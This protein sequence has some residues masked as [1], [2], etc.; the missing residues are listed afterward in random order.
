MSSGAVDATVEWGR[1]RVGGLSTR[2]RHLLAG[3]LL[4][5]ALWEVAGR[6]GGV[7]LAPLSSVLVALV[8][9][10][11]SGRILDPLATTLGRLVVGYALAVGIG[12][13]VGAAMG[14]SA[15][16][17][18]LLDSYVTVLFVTS[19][20]SMLPLLIIFAGTGLGF[21]V[22]VVLLFAVFHVVLI[23][24]SGVADVD[25]DLVD[26]GRVFGARGHRLYRHVLLPAALPAVGA[27]LRV[28][29][30]R[31]IKGVVVAELWIYSGIGN[32]LHGYQ[33]YSQVDYAL[34]VV[35]TLMLLAVASVRS[36]R[37]LEGRYAPWAVREG[38]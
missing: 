23:V 10:Y 15:T 13:P 35:L 8:D 12:V 27:A 30:D 26:T 9:L 1:D 7:T 4:I 38:A 36:L 34:A 16:V 28:G 33:Q 37:W 19:V 6:A 3:G 5:A 18:A 32:L 31:A 14:F 22:F 17:D 24:R 21:Y 11:V 20:S 29:I 2:Q 25:D